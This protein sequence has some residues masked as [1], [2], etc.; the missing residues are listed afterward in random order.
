MGKTL[1]RPMLVAATAVTLLTPLVA[2]HAAADMET[3]MTPIGGGYDIP[4]LEGFSRTAAEDASAPS[5][6]TVVVPSSYGNL[7]EDRA[8][9]LQLAQE[10]TDQVDATCDAVVQPPY[11]G[12]RRPSQSCSTAPMHSTRR[13][14]P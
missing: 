6:D 7:P 10:R 12:A 1:R 5:V 13:N 8:E 9:N 4:T 2:S 3:T 11:T 14:P